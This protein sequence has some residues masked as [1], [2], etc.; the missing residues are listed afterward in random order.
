MLTSAIRQ[1]QAPLQ[2]AI[3]S[4]EH[5]S[6]ASG[7]KGR[8]LSHRPESSIRAT[9]AIVV[10][11]LAS[12]IFP[13]TNASETPEH[14]QVVVIEPELI[15]VIPHD[16][17]AFT[18]GLEIHDGKLYESTGLYGES[19]VRIVNMETGEIEAQYNLSEEYFGEGLT[20]WN[21]SV[22]QLTWRENIAFIYDIDSLEQIGSFSYQGEAWGICNSEETGIWLSDGS[23][24]LQ[25]SENSNINFTD[26]IE[27]L[28]GGGPSDRWN[29][30]ECGSSNGDILANKWYDDSI[31]LIQASNGYVCQKVDFSS[32]RDEFEPES[33][34]VLNGIAKDPV[35]GNYWI[36][37][38][39][40]S[41]YYEV[42][43]EFENIQPNCQ[44]ESS[45]EPPTDCIDCKEGFSSELFLMAFSIAITWLIYASISKRQTEKPPIIREDE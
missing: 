24:R 43:F 14:W 2:P 44:S 31:Y 12:A 45:I 21:N 41:N 30:L 34:G 42:S 29:E 37:G 28:L 26:S 25:N 7:P 1:V 13:L 32:I 20:I 16:D 11:L 18:Q 38:K 6:D 22:I 5:R 27:V 10:C 40:W 15:G 19:S 9:V 23:V 17:S 39:N 35:T 33:S 36:T 3:T 4:M 8:L